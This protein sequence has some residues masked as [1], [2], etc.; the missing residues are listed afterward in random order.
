VLAF[1]LLVS[2]LY[3][4]PQFK[5]SLGLGNLPTSFDEMR[6]DQV[7]GYKTLEIQERVLL[8][9]EDK[10]QLIV[11]EQNVQVDIQISQML[12]NIP[13][14][15]KTKEIH[16]YGKGAFGVDLS[17]MTKDSILVDH[18]IRE[19]YIILEP[20]ALM[21]VEPDYTKTT[22]EDTQRALFAFGEIKMTQEQ[23]TVVNQD[24]KNAM[25]EELQGEDLLAKAD[26]KAI[27]RLQELMEPLIKEIVPGYKIIIQYEKGAAF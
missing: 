6:A 23:Q 21:Y 5:A 9:V 19:V 25:T 20:A 7:M 10:A 14:F 3:L 27:E 18:N 12:W 16:A 8:E 1:L 26:E 13:I 4:F 11:F 17:H 2:S 24:I 15:E 22:Y